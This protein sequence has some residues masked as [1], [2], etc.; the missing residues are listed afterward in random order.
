MC[1]RQKLILNPS[2]SRPLRHGKGSLFEGGVR[3]PAFVWS[4]LLRKR[5]R[6]TNQIFSNVDWLPT[7]YEAAGGDLS[8]LAGYNL[9]GVSQWSSLQGTTPFCRHAMWF[10]FDKFLSAGISYGPRRELPV[11]INAGT[12]TSCMIYEDQYGG[13]FKLLAG[14]VFD[15]T[16][17]GW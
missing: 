13:L 14:N 8:D 7:L 16:F 15:N 11:N 2:S 1:E 12:N 10:F 4:P 6:I 17:A 3:V 9:S 5:G